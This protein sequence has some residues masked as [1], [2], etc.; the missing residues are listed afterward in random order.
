[1]G[2]FSAAWSCHFPARKSTVAVVF[3]MK[4]SLRSLFLFI[5]TPSHLISCYCLVVYSTLVETSHPLHLTPALCLGWF[6]HMSQASVSH[7]SSGY[8]SL[9]WPRPLAL[10]QFRYSTYRH[11]YSCYFYVNFHSVSVAHIIKVQNTIFSI[12]LLDICPGIVSYQLCDLK[13]VD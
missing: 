11:T 7:H 3:Q 9:S 4:Y 12:R 6:P 13:Q 2:E 10:L 1:M 8:S 5:P